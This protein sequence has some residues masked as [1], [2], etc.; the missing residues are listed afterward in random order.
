[1]YDALLLMSIVL[2]VLQEINRS[3]NLMQEK[4]RF[5]CLMDSTHTFLKMTIFLKIKTKLIS[6]ASI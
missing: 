4:P 1:M 5:V 6:V 2:L 3:T